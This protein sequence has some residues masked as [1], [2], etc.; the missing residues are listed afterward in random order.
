MLVAA[1]GFYATGEAVGDVVSG[2]FQ[3]ELR[4][5]LAVTTLLV[6]RVAAASP[7]LLGL[8]GASAVIA[9][10]AAGVIG[11]GLFWP[12]V[13]RRAGRPMPIRRVLAFNGPITVATGATSL[14]QL[15]SL[16]VNA[17][18][19]GVLTSVYAA[20]S[21]LSNPVN[22]AVA[23]MLQVLIP[24]FARSTPDDARSQFRRSR[25]FVILLA[26]AVALSS[27]L[28]PVV[29]HI[30]YGPSFAATAPIL[31]G[32]FVGAGIS[33]ISQIHLA[34]LLVR[35]LTLRSAGVIAG[36]VGAGLALLAVEA[37]L[38]GP[39]GCGVG[40]ALMEC[41]IFAAIFSCY[42]R[43]EAGADREAVLT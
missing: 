16:V 7:F 1:T 43:A 28:A 5:T 2:V 27:L 36:G 17:A 20:A 30:L 18:T 22:L 31:A 11:H 19:S 35:R 4:P 40:F 42:R 14:T 23:T 6:R 8:S 34:Y 12:T 9:L 32:V 24:E 25:R 37:L 3:G 13:S 41:A 39:V 38:G 10:I 29:V 21:R 26:L 15:D 33:A